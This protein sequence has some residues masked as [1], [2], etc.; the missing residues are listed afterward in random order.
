MAPNAMKPDMLLERI[1]RE[2]A[3]RAPDV[4][5]C[6]PDD[7]LPRQLVVRAVE[8]VTGQPRLQRIYDEYRLVEKDDDNFW[9]SAIE[10]LRLTV[11]YD[12]HRLNAIPAEGPLIVV[13]NHPYGVLDGIAIGYLTSQVRSDF[14]VLA[15][16]SLGR[17]E[18]LRP[19]LIP[20][21]FD[22]TQAAVRANVEAKRAAV[23]H[24]TNGGSIVIFPAGGVS[25]APKV[26]G[27][28]VDAPW[29]TFTGRLIATSGATVVPMFFEGQNSWLFH[30][31]SRFSQALREALLLREVVRRIGAD[32][33]AHIGAPI[34]FAD[35]TN[36][37]DRLALIEHL[38]ELVY[39]LDP[40][41]TALPA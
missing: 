19:Y 17:A 23:R 40:E 25:T 29:K 41:S 28:A 34:P 20:I 8:Q 39:G 26:F 37:P 21:S 33:T 4:S 15:N 31:A 22:E 13:A 32:I 12:S 38:R 5:Y 3:Q 35:L 18:A 7:P 27:R 2:M 9:Q 36:W 16:A 11:N 14:K 10:R 24:L 30:L 1:R 6:N